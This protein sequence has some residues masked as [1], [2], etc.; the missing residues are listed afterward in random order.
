[1]RL[2]EVITSSEVDVK[3]EIVTTMAKEGEPML[4]INVLEGG[5]DPIARHISDYPE[6][7]VTETT[8]KKGIEILL[9]SGKLENPDF[10]PGRDEMRLVNKARIRKRNEELRKV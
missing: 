6:W 3:G 7:L 4:G 8:R 5:S 1:M 9:E 10:I 2:K